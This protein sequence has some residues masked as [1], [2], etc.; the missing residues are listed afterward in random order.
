MNNAPDKHTK[1]RSEPIT[2]Y[3]GM[4]NRPIERILS[5]FIH[6]R[7][8]DGEVPMEATATLRARTVDMA[9]PNINRRDPVIYRN[10]NK[11]TSHRSWR[12]NGAYNPSVQLLPIPIRG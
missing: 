8:K 1:T 11:C 3:N 12:T 10:A 4:R 5:N 9:S 7:M 2:I 6:K